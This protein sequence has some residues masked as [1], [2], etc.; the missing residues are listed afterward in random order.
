MPDMGA[1]STTGTDWTASVMSQN[2]GGA[3][4]IW[5]YAGNLTG[6]TRGGIAGIRCV[7]R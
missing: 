2:R 6:T 7:G 5:E 3:W 4:S 1:L